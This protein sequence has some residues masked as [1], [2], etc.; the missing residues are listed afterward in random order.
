MRLLRGILGT[1]FVL[2]IATNMHA[3]SFDCGKAASEVE[4]LICGDDE[5]S[6]L[7]DSL[8]EAYQEALKT[9]R[10]KSQPEAKII[11]S[12]TDLLQ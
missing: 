3:A 10:S 1:F 2:T 9:E 6:K 4:K 8:S 11:E 5:L 7:D 12:Q